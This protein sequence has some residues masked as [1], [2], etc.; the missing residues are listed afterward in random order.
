[1]KEGESGGVTNDWSVEKGSGSKSWQ[2]QRK[3][4]TSGD[5]IFLFRIVIGIEYIALRSV[6]G[7]GKE[8]KEKEKEEGEE[9]LLG[10]NK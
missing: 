1:M 4:N 6:G 7:E 10:N 9:V 2:L 3:G 5:D 8:K